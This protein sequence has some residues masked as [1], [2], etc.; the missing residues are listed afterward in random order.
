LKNTKEYWTNC[1]YLFELLDLRV[2]RGEYSLLCGYPVKPGKIKKNRQI[3]LVLT[4]FVC[5]YGTKAYM[6]ELLTIE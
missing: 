6:F 1:F 2:L 3:M 4:V 5:Y